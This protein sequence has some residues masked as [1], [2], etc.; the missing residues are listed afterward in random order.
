MDED[1]G[2]TPQITVEINSGADQRRIV[3]SIYADGLPRVI[4]VNAYHM[5]MV[6]AGPMIVLLNEDRPGMIGLVGTEFGETGANIANMALSRRGDTAMMVL[7]LDVAPD[8][9]LIN[10]L[11]A[12]PGILKVAVI[13]LPPLEQA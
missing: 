12:R 2:V 7:K 5:D 4:E 13:S 11:R 9:A 6:P 3:G 1:A 10:R 8:E